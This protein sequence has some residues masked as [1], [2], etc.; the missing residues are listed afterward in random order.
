MTELMRVPIPLALLCPPTIPAPPN[1]VTGPPLLDVPTPPPPVIEL[2]LFVEMRFL[3]R[4]AGLAKPVISLKLDALEG[5]ERGLGK[6]M[7]TNPT[8]TGGPGEQF[9]A[10]CRLIRSLPIW[11]FESLVRVARSQLWEAAVAADVVDVVAVEFVGTS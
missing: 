8:G 5:K 2:L 3:L 7:L 9:L 4:L 11:A 10:L 6:A 1:G